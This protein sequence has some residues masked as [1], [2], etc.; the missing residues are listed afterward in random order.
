MLL[1]VTMVAKS[2]KCLILETNEVFFFNHSYC[3]CCELIY[4]VNSCTKK[5]GCQIT[6]YLAYNN[7]H[8]L[9]T[10]EVDPVMTLKSNNDNC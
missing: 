7:I 4:V 5:L 3:W 8:D 1:E 6:I 9:V 2:V 10:M